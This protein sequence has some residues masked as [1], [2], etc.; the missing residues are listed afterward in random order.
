[1]HL[2]SDHFPPVNNK[3]I[4]AALLEAF[5]KD[6]FIRGLISY[7]LSL[8]L[9]RELHLNYLKKNGS[10]LSKLCNESNLRASFPK[11][12]RGDKSQLLIF[13]LYLVETLKRSLCITKRV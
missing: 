13:T 11:D 4:E 7:G 9:S 12:Y 5:I 8:N 6:I 3:N 1:M 10:K 2:S